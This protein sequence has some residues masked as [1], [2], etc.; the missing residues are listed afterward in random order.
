M[1]TGASDGI[2][3][4]F[5]HELAERGFHIVLHGRNPEKLQKKQ[6]LLKT[7]YPA[8][9]TRLWIADAMQDVSKEEL[10]EAVRGLHLTLLINNVGGLPPGVDPY[11]ALDDQSFEH[12]DRTVHMN[13]GFATKLEAALLSVLSENQPSCIL[14]ISSLAT[15]GTVSLRISFFMQLTSSA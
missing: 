1:V 6:A 15:L 2:G 14:N 5:A 9:K 12:I 4:G 8:V 10:M 3:E 11:T 7:A 13:V